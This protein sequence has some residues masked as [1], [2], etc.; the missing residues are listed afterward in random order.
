MWEIN[1]NKPTHPGVSLGEIE[2]RSYQTT[3]SHAALESEEKRE[4]ENSLSLPQF[5]PWN[6][7][8]CLHKLSLFA[9][10]NLEL[11]SLKRRFATRLQNGRVSF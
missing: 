2:F 7:P 1:D 11:V 3:G 10:I 6:R 4:K 5:N 8:T 9:G